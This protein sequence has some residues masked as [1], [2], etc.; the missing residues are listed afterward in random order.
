MP[1]WNLRPPRRRG[2]VNRRARR[3]MAYENRTTNPAPV[4]NRP[5]QV[6]GYGPEGHPNFEVRQ[7]YREYNRSIPRYPAKGRYPRPTE[8]DHIAR[9]IYELLAL[10]SSINSQFIRVRVYNGHVRLEGVVIHPRERQMAARLA[11]SV[12][13]VRSVDNRLEVDF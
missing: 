13:G 4:E 3:E 6:E 9:D 10:N 7:G 1:I 11:G 12:Y 5:I 8:D 2:G